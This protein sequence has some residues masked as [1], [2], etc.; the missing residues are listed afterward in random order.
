MALNELVDE[1]ES[2]NFLDEIFDCIL[3]WLEPDDLP[4][5]RDELSPIAVDWV[6]RA[7]AILL[8]DKWRS[9]IGQEISALEVA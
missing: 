6:T 7:L 9:R 4:H 8:P 3:N 1:P 5:L 2:P